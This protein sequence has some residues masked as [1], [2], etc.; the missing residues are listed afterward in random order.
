V[1]CKTGA[2]FNVSSLVFLKIIQKSGG[3]LNW[4]PPFC[5]FTIAQ[6]VSDLTNALFVSTDWP[7]FGMIKKCASSFLHGCLEM[8]L[9]K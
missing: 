3:F 7:W 5:F 6:Y 2:F 8:T 1:P 9:T 4:K